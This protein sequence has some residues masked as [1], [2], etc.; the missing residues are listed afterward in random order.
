MERE[1]SSFITHYKDLSNFIEPRRGRFFISDRNRGEKRHNNIIN[2][3]GSQALRTA[4]SGMFAGTMSPTQPWFKLEPLDQ[5]M[6]KS[7]AVRFWLYRVEQLLRTIFFESN[8]YNQ[9]PVMLG[10]LL[11]FATGAMSHVDDFENVARFYTHTAGSYMI[12]QNERCEVDT[13]V[14]QKENTVEQIV[15]EFGLKNCS[16]HV[17]YQYDQ[18]NYDTWYPVT[19]LI[20]PNP[21]HK[22]D[23]PLAKFKPYRSVWFEPGNREKDQFLKKSGFDEFP[24]HCPRWSVTGEDIYGTNCPGML[25]LGDVKALQTMEKRKAQAVDKLVNPPLK[26]P[27][28]LRNVPISS[29]PGSVNIYDG[30]G[31][32]EGLSPVYQVEPRINEMRA[33]IAAVENRIS[34]A[35]FVDLFLAISTMEGIQPKNQL[36]LSQ[37]NAERLLMLG[38][39][40]QRLQQDFQGKL[41]TRTFNQ[42]MR[43]GILPE[44]PEELQGQAL[45]VRYISSLAMAQRASEVGAIERVS[46]FT[47][48]LAT[49]NPEVLDKFNVDE[50]LDQYSQMT[51]AAPSLI[52]PTEIVAAKREER[53]RQQQIAAQAELM[54]QATAS[55]NQSAGAMKQ[56]AEADNVR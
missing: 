9:T 30:D 35:F 48:Q 53:A 51:G 7:D 46:L 38:P 45:G 11:L 39:P 32:K 14:L 21:N 22:P 49:I 28:S 34:E 4:Q 47:A 55:M 1:R 50:A 31:T 17:K 18:G 24:V 40:L 12:A 41:I 44:A 20:E 54:Q 29:L 16:A 19:Q 33:D 13:F 15:R 23:N 27:P 42:A 5:D 37:R 25:S 6:M 8:L 52:V 3:R 10:E 2:S 36:E 43:A 26:G 56:S